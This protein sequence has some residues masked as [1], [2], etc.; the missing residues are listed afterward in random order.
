MQDEGHVESDQSRIPAIHSCCHML[1][2]G[3]GGG[4]TCSGAAVYTDDLLPLKAKS[5]PAKRLS[6]SLWSS[7]S[8]DKKEF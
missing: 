7:I 1:N 3:L 8:V 6:I 4:Y 2:P 5:R